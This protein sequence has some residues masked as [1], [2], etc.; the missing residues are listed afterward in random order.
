MKT[1]MTIVINKKAKFEYEFIR[2]EVAGIVLMGSEVKSIRAGK[3]SIAESYCVFD[4]DE[5]FLKNANI[6]EIGT[7]FSHNSKQDRKLLLRK[8]ELLKFKKELIKGFTV[9]PYKVFINEKGK[10]KVEVVLA[11]GKKNYDKRESIKE[12]DVQKQIKNSF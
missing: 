8:T 4:G 12:R 3:I 10:I 9:I 7:A 11:K 5:L 6:S 2:V 1:N